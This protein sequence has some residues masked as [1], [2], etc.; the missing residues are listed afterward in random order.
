MIQKTA[1]MPKAPKIESLWH[2]RNTGDTTN[3][4]IAHASRISDNNLDFI[5]TL[6]KESAGTWDTNVINR[7]NKNGTIDKGICQFNSRYFS[8]LYKDPN[9]NNPEWQVNKCYEMYMDWYKRG[10]VGKRMF[11]YNNRESAK[12]NFYLQ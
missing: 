1:E 5:A 10:I 9:W 7:S 8:H 6:D 3:A 11:G 4:V 2:K 12:K